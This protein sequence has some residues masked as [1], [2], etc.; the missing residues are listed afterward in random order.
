MRLPL[1]KFILTQ[2]FGDRPEY[3][4]Q[5]GLKGH[6]GI[7][8]KTRYVGNLWGWWYDYKGWRNVYA[9]SDGIVKVKYDLGGYGTHIILRDFDTEDEYLYAHLKNAKVQDGEFVREGQVIGISG[10][11]GNTS[12]PHLHFAHKPNNS[13]QANGFNGFQDP[14]KLFR[15]KLLAFVNNPGTEVVNKLKEYMPEFEF[16]IKNYQADLIVPQGTLTTDKAIELIDR[17]GIME[18]FVFIFYTGMNAAYEVASYYPKKNMA[19]C[20]IPLGGPLTIPVHAFLHL[21]RKHINFNKYEPYIEDVERYPT[22]WSDMANFDNAGWAFKE[23]YA[24]LN[25]YLIL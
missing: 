3:Y 4:A 2:K 15:K 11:S 23:Q 22:S 25:N 16:E 13:N 7:D 9:V 19:F 8:L 1:D 10:N 5:F 18:P 14:L 12:G 17:L 20:T 24:Q 21:A 6:E